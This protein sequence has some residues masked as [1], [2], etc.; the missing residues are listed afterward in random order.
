MVPTMMKGFA[1]GAE[2]GEMIDTM[3]EVVPKM[4]EACMKS[5][6]ED[7]RREMLSFCRGMLDP[8]E[9]RFV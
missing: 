4:M 6:K 8:M 7:E 5:M 1:S 2:S 9:N 3:H